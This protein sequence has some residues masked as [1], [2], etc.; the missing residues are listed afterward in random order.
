MKYLMWVDRIPAWVFW[1]VV[2]GVVL[3][4]LLPVYP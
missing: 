3:G 2:G 4:F 1:C